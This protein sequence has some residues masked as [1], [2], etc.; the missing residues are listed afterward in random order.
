MDS[1]AFCTATGTELVPASLQ[2]GTSLHKCADIRACM[3]RIDAATDANR[4]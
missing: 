1:C 2:P 4:Q 3:A